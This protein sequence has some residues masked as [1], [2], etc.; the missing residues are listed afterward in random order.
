MLEVLNALPVVMAI[1]VPLDHEFIE[2]PTGKKQTDFET[3]FG[4]SMKE[5]MRKVNSTK[6]LF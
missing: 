4:K 1:P 3:D 5:G 6:Y 2:K